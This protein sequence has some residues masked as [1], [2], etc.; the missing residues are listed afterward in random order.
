MAVTTAALLLPMSAA[1]AGTGAL[2]G[3]CSPGDVDYYITSSSKNIL[4]THKFVYATL[5]PGASGARTSTY[6]TSYT[7]SVTVSGSAKFSAGIILAQA[8]TTIGMQLQD[9]GTKTSTSSF[10]LTAHNGTSQY[11]DYVWFEGTRRGVGTWKSNNCVAGREKPY[12]SGTW[13]SWQAQ[14]SGVINC[15]DDAAILSKYGSFSV[16]HYAVKTC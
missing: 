2:A 13:G 7:S 16:Q 9:S 11:H 15:D 8:E 1:I 14:Y 5:A 6:T 10:T 12:G 4:F 3:T